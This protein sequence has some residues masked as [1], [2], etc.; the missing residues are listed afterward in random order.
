MNVKTKSRFDDL[1]RAVSKVKP[2]IKKKV[3]KVK[4]RK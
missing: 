2:P 4:K 3:P 1:M